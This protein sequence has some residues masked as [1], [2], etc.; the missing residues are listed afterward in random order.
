MYSPADLERVNHVDKLARQTPLYYAARR[1]HLQM[2]A[3]LVEKGADVT[4]TD[5]SNKTVV[6]YAKKAKFSD[7]ADYLA[8]QLKKYRD[9]KPSFEEPERKAGGRR[10]EEPLKDSKSTYKI[11]RYNE[12]GESQ[13]L[14]EEEVRQLLAD[15]PQLAKYMANPELIP[16]EA[17]TEF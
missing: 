14:T 11:V 12:K 1:G 17:I 8:N 7:V 5:S 3:L 2:A 16:Q 6:D 4:V 15:R 10:K 13:D 9:V